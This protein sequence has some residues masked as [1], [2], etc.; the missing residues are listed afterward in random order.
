[1]PVIFV[2]QDDTDLVDNFL[3]GYSVL[4]TP[5]LTA[6]IFERCLDSNPE[7]CRSKQARYHLA[8]H[9]QLSNT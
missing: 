9:L 6:P 2:K 8:T 7:S 5:L 3:A 1:M 4:E